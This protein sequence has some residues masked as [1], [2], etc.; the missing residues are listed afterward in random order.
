MDVRRE[1]VEHPIMPSEVKT[2]CQSHF[3]F[4]SYGEK[5]HPDCRNLIVFVTEGA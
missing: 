5:T 2:G 3:R 4:R 1:I